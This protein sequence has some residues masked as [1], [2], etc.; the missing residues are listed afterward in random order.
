MKQN[1]HL[2]H[3][4]LVVNRIENIMVLF[5]LYHNSW[6]ENDLKYLFNGKQITYYVNDSRLLHSNQN[7]AQF[8]S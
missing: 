6:K 8:A 5:S 7:F 2:R 1:P 4:Q 3:F